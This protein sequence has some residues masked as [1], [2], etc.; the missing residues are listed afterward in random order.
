[1]RD[2]LR[3]ITADDESHLRP[4]VLRLTYSPGDTILREGTMG[5][6]LGL[7]RRG[8]V[9]M[10]SRVA[11]RTAVGELYA[12]EL[13]GESCLVGEEAPVSFVALDE[14]EVEL[15][16]RV[17]LE[18]RMRAD[19]PFETRLYRSLTWALAGRVRALSD[20]LVP[21]LALV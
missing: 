20:V 21:A 4:E 11:H 14:V 6:V 15:V 13:F 16:P 3:F 7:I 19:P 12:G 2:V 1:M 5:D 18:A 8:R 17:V 9:R 10:E